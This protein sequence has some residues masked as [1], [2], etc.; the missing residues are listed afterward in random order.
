MSLGLRP[1]Q[2]GYKTWLI[3]PQ[4]GD[5]SWAEGRVAT[6]Y[7]PIAVRWQKTPPGL[8]LEI[9]VP[10]G[11]SGTIGVPTSSNTDSVIDND[12]PVK[13]GEKMKAAS[14]SE[15]SSGAR[16]G[17]AYLADV[18]PGMHVIQVTGGEK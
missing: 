13:K 6:P 15:D 11:T 12:R 2:P 18:G 10:V 8:R 7:G 9:N 4:P 3:E 5:L 14:A 17:Y 16:P 1:I